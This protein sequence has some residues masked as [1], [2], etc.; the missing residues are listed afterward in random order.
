MAN[1]LL[2]GFKAVTLPGVGVGVLAS[3]VAAKYARPLAVSTL[4]LGF[5]VK[6]GSERI[7][8][9]ARAAATDL[10]HEARSA[11]SD[12]ADEARKP[13]ASAGKGK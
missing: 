8:Q 3:V 5:Q 11:A 6:D 13:A 2:L 10:A 9:E 12:L 7:W 1:P 4:R